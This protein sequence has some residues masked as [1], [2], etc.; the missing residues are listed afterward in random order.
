MHCKSLKVSDRCLDTARAQGPLEEQPH[1]HTAP[2]GHLTHPAALELWVR[3]SGN[4]AESFK[5]E[6]NT[7]AAAT[8]RWPEPVSPP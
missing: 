3:R 1:C 4:R 2:T 6:T 5:E 8:S 7:D